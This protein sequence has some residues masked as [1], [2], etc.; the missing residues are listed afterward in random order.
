[1]TPKRSVPDADRKP[2]LPGRA[3]RLVLLF[4]MLA[5]LLQSA[6]AAPAPR[7]DPDDGGL[8]LP[9]GFCALVVADGLGPVRNLAV[10]PNGD[11]FAARRLRDGEGGGVLAL[12]DVDGD[13]RADER[14]TFGEGDGHGLALTKTHLVYAA[15]DRIVRWPW[16]G[17]QLE[18]SGSPD[19]LVSGFPD[20]QEH[21][22]KAIAIAPDGALYV[23]VG[24]PSNACQKEKRTPGSAGLDPCPQRERQAGIWRYRSDR[25]GQTHAPGNRFASGLRHALAL[26]VEP[27]TGALWAVVNGRDALAS[28]WGFDAERNAS[29]PAEE[30]VRVEEGS[31]LGWPYCYHDGLRDRKVLA[32]EYGGDGEKQGRCAGRTSPDLAFPAHWAPMA[33]L[34]HS[35]RSFPERYGHGA[36][37]AFR[38]SWNRA[39]LPQEGY[40]VVFVPFESGLPARF[41]TFAI[42][43]ADPTAFRMTGLAEGP[44]GS[45]FIAAGANRKIWRV[46]AEATGTGGGSATEGSSPATEP[47]T[48]EP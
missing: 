9:K 10:A 42:G 17:G 25:E 39:P 5:V 3:W 2:P 30:M 23:E 4:E 34:F 26:G 6:P 13:G 20:Q 36:F 27:G 22:A 16:Q 21:R 29:L 41:E 43:A 31:D 45:L 48:D 32:P 28:L 24:A 19:I 7:C 44:D 8:R 18:P 37:V 11:V 35:G 38:G 33:L 47:A 12:R 15:H 14:R 46:M 40:R 1:M